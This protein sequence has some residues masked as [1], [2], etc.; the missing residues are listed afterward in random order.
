MDY[1]GYKITR[2]KDYSHYVITRI[3]TGAMP[4]SLTGYFTSEGRCV[5]FIDSYEAQKESEDK[6]SDYVKELLKKEPVKTK[7]A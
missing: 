6:R 3:G 2:T 4:A 7:E 1:K 5:Q